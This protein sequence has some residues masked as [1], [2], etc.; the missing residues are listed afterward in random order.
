MTDDNSTHS[1]EDYEHQPWY[2]YSSLM[3]NLAQPS[4]KY[5]SWAKKIGLSHLGE[6]IFKSRRFIMIPHYEWA[7]NKRVPSAIFNLYLETGVKTKHIGAAYAQTNG[8][9]AFWFEKPWDQDSFYEDNVV[10]VPCFSI[11]NIHDVVKQYDKMLDKWIKDVD[12]LIANGNESSA[13]YTFLENT[14]KIKLGL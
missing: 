13:L 5:N 8:I 9:I 11:D 1:D 4:N 6:D 14:W 12:N 10:L 3:Y 2:S 7:Q